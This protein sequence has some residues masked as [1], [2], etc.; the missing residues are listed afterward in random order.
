VEE[1]LESQYL[2]A[3]FMMDSMRCWAK[4]V[5]SEASVTECHTILD[6]RG[7]LL[8]SVK[9]EIRPMLHFVLSHLFQH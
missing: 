1:G 6:K 8:R 2:G 5:L 9:L 7:G 4:A 3:V